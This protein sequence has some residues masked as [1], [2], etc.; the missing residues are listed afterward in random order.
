MIDTVQLL[1]RALNVEV[2]QLRVLPAVKGGAPVTEGQILPLSR[3]T[4]T[5]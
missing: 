5:L 1:D 2:R 3:A 4:I